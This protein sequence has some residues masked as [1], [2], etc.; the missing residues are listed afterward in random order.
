[1][2]TKNMFLKKNI[3][4]I[5]VEETS[6]S[7]GSRKVIV[8]KPNVP[9]PCFEAFTYGYLPAGK[10]WGLHQHEDII[11][12][13][14]VIKGDGIIRDQQK[15]EEVF[16]PGDRFIFPANTFHEIENTSKDTD[17]FYFIRLRSK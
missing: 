10:K 1:M 16:E 12:V 15:N 13:C 6:H 8:E 3:N 14:I 5:P 17:E 11:E 7:A 9:S 2:P 4:S